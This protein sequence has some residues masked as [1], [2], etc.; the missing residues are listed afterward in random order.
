MSG[1]QCCQSNLRDE[2]DYSSA[3]IVTCVFQPETSNTFVVPAGVESLSAL[4]LV[5][6][7]GG[8]DSLGFEGIFETT[9]GGQ[10]IQLDFQSFDVFPGVREQVSAMSS[11]STGHAEQILD[12]QQILYLVVAGVGVGFT[13]N[14]D[15]GSG[16]NGA[17][18]ING[19]GP[20]GVSNGAFGQG[21]GGG[22]TG[23]S[24]GTRGLFSDVAANPPSCRP[25]PDS[26]RR[27]RTSD[28]CDR[29]AGHR[30]W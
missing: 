11:T 29:L 24:W 5:G 21:G 19:G 22:A 7:I 20:T 1:T 18:G 3:S 15:T 17:G 23:T 16:V 26:S 2:C 25:A 12:A 28:R 27:R 9:Q 8:G 4:T 6:G 14:S 30:G 10:A 13:F